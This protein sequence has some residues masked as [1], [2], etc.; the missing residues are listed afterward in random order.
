MISTQFIPAR[1]ADKRQRNA[2]IPAGRF[3][4]DRVC[5][6]LPG[7]LSR[8]DHRHADAVLDAVRRVIEFQLGH[9][10]LPPHP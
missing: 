9:H 2:G 1:R 5:L 7:L 4:D 6:D 3:D 10:G 8:L